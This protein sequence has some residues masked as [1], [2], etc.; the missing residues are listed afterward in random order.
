V[1]GIYALV[2][3]GTDWKMKIEQAARAPVEI[4]LQVAKKPLQ[5]IQ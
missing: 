5:E 1:S 2:S 3:I 4:V